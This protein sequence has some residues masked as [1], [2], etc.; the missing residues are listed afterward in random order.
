MAYA[1]QLGYEPGYFGQNEPKIPGWAA[2]LMA[3]AGV[4][5]PAVGKDIPGIGASEEAR[6]RI[7]S[8]F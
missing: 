5:F 6:R 7:S 3:E 2:A 8:F 1:S 4:C